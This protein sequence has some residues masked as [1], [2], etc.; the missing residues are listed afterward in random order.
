MVRRVLLIVPVPAPTFL[1]FANPHPPK[2][3]L[4]ALPGHQTWKLKLS[5]TQWLDDDMLP[6]R[7]LRHLKYVFKRPY[8][9]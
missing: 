3:V 1:E 2:W 9:P 8:K 7:R 6:G 4:P 5:T